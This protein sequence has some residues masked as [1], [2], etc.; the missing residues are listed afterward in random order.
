MDIGPS[1]VSALLLPTELEILVLSWAISSVL[2]HLIFV[3][4]WER[5]VILDQTEEILISSFVSNVIVVVFSTIL[6]LVKD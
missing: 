1:L 6:L 5:Y 2:A 4:T 3:P